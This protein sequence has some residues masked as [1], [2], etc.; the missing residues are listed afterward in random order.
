MAKMIPDWIDSESSAENRVFDL[1]ASDPATKDWTVLHSLSLSRTEKWPYGEIDFVVIVP[2]EGIVCLEV[3]GGGVSC[4]DGIYRGTDRY[5]NSYELRRSPWEQARV[6]MQA[7]RK[8]VNQYF[9]ETA[10]ESLCPFGCAVVFPDVTCPPPTP[11]FERWEA[12]D[13]ENLKQPISQSIMRVARRRL[14]D[15]QPRT[16]ERLPTASEVRAIRNYLRPDFERIVAKGPALDQ[17]DS[18]LMRLTEEQYAALDM[19][20]EEP[21]CLFEGAAGTGKTLLALEYAR[22]ANLA[23]SKVL[24]VCFN[25]L[26]GKWLR[27]RAKDMKGVTAGPW[28]EFAKETIMGSNMDDSLKKEFV[29]L[30]RELWRQGK[31]G[32]DE[33][34]D[35]VYPL[36]YG[37]SVPEPPFDVLVVDEAQDMAKKSILDSLDLTVRGGLAGGRWAMFG[38]S[39]QKI[40]YDGAVKPDEIL[41]QYTTNFRTGMLT[42][43]CRNT[44]QIA[45]KTAALTGFERS[46]FVLNQ[47]TGFPVERKYWRTPSDLRRSLENRIVRLTTRENVSIQNIVVLSPDTLKN[48]KLFEVEKISGFP[49][50]NISSAQSSAGAADLKFSNIRTFKGLE[51]QVVIIVDIDKID[52]EQQSLLYVAMSRAKSLLILMIHESI[53]EAV[54][55]LIGQN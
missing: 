39:T 6:S 35:G 14:R 44:R 7:L 55:P 17:A 48:S 36:Y 42:L 45:E 8:S 19:L 22:R 13:C 18:T 4:E 3:K 23:G 53:R 21:R 5:G 1:L 47:E 38:D 25:L 46:P 30:D 27:Q 16:G 32:K 29:E 10:L 51:S 24:F 31:P 34:F 33:L 20:K 28:Y 50:V 15:F 26:L 54:E 43:N 41:S 40:L 2:R 49:L 37:Q 52:D 11:E 9:G 12:I